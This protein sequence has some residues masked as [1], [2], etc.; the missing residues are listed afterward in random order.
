MSDDIHGLSGAYALDAVDDLERARFESHLRGCAECRAEVDSLREV[1][2]ALGSIVAVAPSSAVRANVLREIRAVR[3][4]P[5]IVAPERHRLGA[6]TP[7]VRWLSSAA[8]A[9]L[10]V[11]GG[12]V[13]HPW[14]S[15]PPAPVD[16]T[17]QV[18]QAPDARTVVKKVRGGTAKI[19]W[20][21]TV[22]KAVIVASDLK[23]APAGK[24]YELWLFD[25]RGNATRAGL[26]PAG[27]QQQV[28]QI[29]N[30]SVAT[31]SGAGITVEPAGGSD[32]PTTSPIAAFTFA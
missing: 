19:T 17:S 29:L 14:Q 24:V 5:P 20:S 8:A 16:A 25:S 21:K 18:V 15:T 23:A 1:G 28:S 11:V 7:V 13:W 22:G 6:R 9:M 30:G 3:P 32:Q 4:L 26:L 2:A 10:I 27:D 12:L 31:A